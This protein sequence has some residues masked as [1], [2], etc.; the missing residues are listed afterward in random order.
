MD[1]SSLVEAKRHGSSLATSTRRAFD[2]TGG[3]YVVLAI[4][5]CNYKL[6]YFVV[7][8]VMTLSYLLIYDTILGFNCRDNLILKYQTSE[9]KTSVWQ[10]LYSSL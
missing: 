4:P 2:V 3:S 10:L 5:K 6:I 8:V 9:K 1:P 7:N